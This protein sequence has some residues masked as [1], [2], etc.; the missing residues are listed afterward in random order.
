[1][2]DIDYQA[3]LDDCLE[4]VLVYRNDNDWKLSIESLYTGKRFYEASRERATSVKVLELNA[5]TSPKW[6]AYRSEYTVNASPERVF[7][8]SSNLEHVKRINNHLAELEIIEVIDENTR[9]F[10]TISKN[11]M[12]GL[13]S[14]RELITILR[15]T[16][17][18]DS[19]NYY[20]L[21]YHGHVD[22]PKCPVVDEYIRG[23]PYPSGRFI[24]P[25]EGEPNK[26]SVIGISQSDVKLFPQTLVEKLTPKTIVSHI[27]T[28]INLMSEE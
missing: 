15:C 7:N 10:Q 4:K 22:H 13:I 23:I 12:M 5:Q 3:I 2:A 24:Y 28:S 6:R 25:V 27:K 18:S 11:L 9:V 8:F 20:Y 16:Q 1:M 17:I 26:S 21:I 19:N 14:P